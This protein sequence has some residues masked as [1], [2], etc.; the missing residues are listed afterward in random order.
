MDRIASPS[1]DRPRGSNG[2]NGSKDSHVRPLAWFVA[3]MSTA[4]VVSG[5]SGDWSAVL[6]LVA[7]VVLA[8]AF[9]AQGYDVYRKPGPPRG[10]GD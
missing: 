7:A 3:I 1:R 8:T 4:T 5:R 2:S 6:A 9:L 10:D